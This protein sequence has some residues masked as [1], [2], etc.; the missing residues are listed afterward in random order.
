M[1]RFTYLIAGLL[2]VIH[3]SP[4]TNHQ[5]AHAQEPAKAVKLR[6]FGQSFFQ[7]ETSPG[8]KV[9]FDPHA[10]PEFGRHVVEADV[11]VCTHL[12]NDHTTM[13]AIPE[14]KAARIFYGLE[15]VK[16]GRPAEWKK[17]DEK[18]GQVRVRTV[19]TYHDASDGLERGKNAVFVVEADGLVF[20]HLGDLGH[21]LTAAQVKAIGPVDVLMVPVGGIYTING[22][23]AKRVVGQLKP[24]RYVLPMHYGVPGYDALLPADE[25]LNGQ[26]DVQK[27]P[28]TNELVIPL[29]AKPEKPTVVVLGWKKADAP[30]KPKK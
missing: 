9:V 19:G 5:S 21:D 11:I 28:D 30:A 10:I 24:R 1:T 7:L 12:H 2:I 22:G 8:K 27:M 25:F 23:Q 6:W 20:C 29:D 26:P 14:P 3:Q 15:E 4:I 18:V 16:K 17:I 13:A